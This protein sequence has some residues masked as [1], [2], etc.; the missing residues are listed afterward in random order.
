[1]LNGCKNATSTIMVQVYPKPSAAFNYSISTNGLVNF[2]DASS[3]PSIISWNWCFNATANTSNEQNPSYTC[4]D[5]TVN[6]N[7]CMVVNSEK[8]CKD[9]ICKTVFFNT[10]IGINENSTDNKF[11]IFPNPVTDILT[12]EITH[13]GILEVYDVIGTIV[14]RQSINPGNNTIEWRDKFNKNKKDNGYFFSR[15]TIKY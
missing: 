1:M 12:I 11:K 6:Y 3:N 10:A 14:Y 7:V 2:F 8:G 4:V 9:T 15:K 13:S 5:T